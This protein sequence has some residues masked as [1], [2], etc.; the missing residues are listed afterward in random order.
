MEALSVP[1]LSRLTM[2]DGH[3]AP[4]ADKGDIVVFD[5]HERT[6]ESGAVYLTRIEKN[7]KP[8]VGRA[9]L[10][11]DGHWWLERFARRDVYGPIGSDMMQRVVVGRIKAVWKNIN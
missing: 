8:Y 9:W 10:Y 3:A 5:P 1:A 4:F 2:D 11:G 7:G 6:L